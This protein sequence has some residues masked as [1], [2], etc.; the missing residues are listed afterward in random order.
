MDFGRMVAAYELVAEKGEL[1]IE[2][3]GTQVLAYREG[4]GEKGAGLGV[5][6]KLR[7]L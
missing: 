6:H 5:S 4:E 3:F 2:E 7:N 1:G